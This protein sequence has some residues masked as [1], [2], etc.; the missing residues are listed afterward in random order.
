MLGIIQSVCYIISNLLTKKT[1]IFGE[2]SYEGSCFTRATMSSRIQTSASDS[3]TIH[4]PVCNTAFDK[5]KVK[6]L[7]TPEGAQ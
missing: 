5:V 7:S 3:R 4:F 2:R 1:M 6:S